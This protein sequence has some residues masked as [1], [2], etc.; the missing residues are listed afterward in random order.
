MLIQTFIYELLQGHVF[1]FLRYLPRR[2]VAGSGAIMFNH[3]RTCQADFQSSSTILYSHQQR[4]GFWFP[5]V[6]AST[7][8]IWRFHASFIRV[9]EVLSHCGFEVHFS[10]D[11]EHLFVGLF[12][13]CCLLWRNVCTDLLG[14]DV[15]PPPCSYSGTLALKWWC[16][17]WRCWGVTG[18]RLFMMGG[19]HDGIS[20]L[21]EE[22]ERSALMLFL[23]PP[24]EDPVRRQL[25][26]SRF[27]G[28]HRKLNLL[29]PWSTFPASRNKCLLFKWPSLWYFVTAA[30][31]D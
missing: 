9:C 18:V 21:L 13:I 3:W 20:V 27:E 22:E 24:W 25:S 5:H 14:T 30:W 31:A 15:C 2:R 17:G 10:S 28:P 16:L 29:A 12:A 23:C 11:V 4:R 6:L 8:V 19:F 7:V 26:A 1:I